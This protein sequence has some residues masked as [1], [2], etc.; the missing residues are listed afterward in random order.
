MVFIWD[1]AGYDE[2]H[3]FTLLHHNFRRRIVTHLVRPKTYS[4]R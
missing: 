4:Q 3:S 1:G 2:L